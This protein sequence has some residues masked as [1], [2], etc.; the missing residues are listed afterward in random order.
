LEIKLREVWRCFAISNS[1][2]RLAAVFKH[3]HST[4]CIIGVALPSKTCLSKRKSLL[5][6]AINP[7]IIWNVVASNPLKS[8]IL[9]G[10]PVETAASQV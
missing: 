9:R 3:E 10:V 1:G 4:A 6:V 2:L 8:K 5:F 7:L